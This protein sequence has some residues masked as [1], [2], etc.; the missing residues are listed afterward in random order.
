VRDGARVRISR[1]GAALGTGTVER[2]QAGREV[3]REAAA[4]SECGV[5]ISTAAKLAPQDTLEFYRE[6]ERTRTV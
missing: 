6:E 5:Q 1:Q 3:I 2:L 4:G